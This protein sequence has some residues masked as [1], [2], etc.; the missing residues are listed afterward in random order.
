MNTGIFDTECER[1]VLSSCLRS[2]DD[3]VF[4]TANLDVECFRDAGNRI[5]FAAIGTAIGNSGSVDLVEVSKLAG[6]SCSASFVC[7]VM[8]APVAINQDWHVQR[9]SEMKAARKLEAVLKSSLYAI[10]SANGNMG[11]AISQAREAVLG[12]EID[13]SGKN[14]SAVNIASLV[15]AQADRIEDAQA[16]GRNRGIPSGFHDLDYF[17]DGFQAGDLVVVAGRPSMGK[18]SLAVDF[19]R[20]MAGYAPGLF[21]SLEMG[22]DQLTDRF[23]APMADVNLKKLRSGGLDDDTMAKIVE[24]QSRLS[25]LPIYVDDDPGIDI[26]KI[27]SK[28]M[29]QVYL[30]KIKWV[31]LDYL[32]LVDSAG[33]SREEEVS[34]ITRRLKKC[35]KE[36]GV[37]IIALSQLNR[38]CEERAD[39]KPLLSDLRES[40][41]IEQDADVVM[42]VWRGGY[43]F[44]QN[45]NYDGMAEILLR[46]HRNGP[47]GDVALAWREGVSSFGNLK[48]QSI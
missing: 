33:R 42:F 5:L 21:L 40:G 47:T 2:L 15:D 7:E 46:K 3:A 39:K 9:L 4:F 25:R 13:G 34:A 16:N 48:K 30:H 41:A 14:R 20:Y 23:V 37:P 44:P 1:S 11:E 12:I 17:T 29:N 28:V 38:K 43:Y 19:A 6:G 45:A 32:Q 26:A 8:D 27:H 22:A 35:A 18:T 31:V 24:A 36:F 10:E